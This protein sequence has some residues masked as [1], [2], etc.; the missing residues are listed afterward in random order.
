MTHVLRSS[1][2]QSTQTTGLLFIHSQYFTPSLII[3]ASPSPAVACIYL[4]VCSLCVRMAIGMNG[5]WNEWLYRVILLRRILNLLLLSVPLLSNAGPSGCFCRQPKLS[6]VCHWLVNN[7]LCYKKHYAFLPS[8][9]RHQPRFLIIII[10]NFCIALFSGVPKLT[11]FYNILH[12]LSFTNIIH[13]IMTTDNVP[14][15]KQQYIKKMNHYIT[16]S[17]NNNK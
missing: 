13:I 9:H 2:S 14:Y 3:L 15:E 7:K 11:A 16:T 8:P 10:N 4:L 12:F 6:S 1:R 17:N 5:R